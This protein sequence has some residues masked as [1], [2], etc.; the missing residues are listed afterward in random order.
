MINFMYFEA[1]FVVEMVG[2]K[3]VLSEYDFINTVFQ[4]CSDCSG[5]GQSNHRI[6][7]KTLRR[8]SMLNFGKQSFMV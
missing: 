5:W 6:V 1:E 7:T 2:Q 3:H 8:L 4:C